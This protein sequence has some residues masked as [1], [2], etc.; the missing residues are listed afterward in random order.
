MTDN[1]MAQLLVFTKKTSAK[2]WL[3]MLKVMLTIIIAEAAIML[4]FT[5]LQLS[6]LG[7]YELAF[8]DAL[9]LGITVAPVLYFFLLL[10]LQRDALKR[11]KRRLAMYDSLTG[12]PRRML[13][14]ELVEY[15]ISKA[16]REHFRAALIVIDPNRLSDIN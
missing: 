7:N 4:L 9:L 13:F 15:E 2:P 5:V 11:Q 12:L 14:H 10:P 3:I 8:L 16:R 1:M 6:H